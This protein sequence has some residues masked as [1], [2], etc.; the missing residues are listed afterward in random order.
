MRVR[1]HEYKIYE[2]IRKENATMLKLKEI[3]AYTSEWV[4][5][6]LSFAFAPL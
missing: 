1:G 6:Y 4:D 5:T 2:L 3:L